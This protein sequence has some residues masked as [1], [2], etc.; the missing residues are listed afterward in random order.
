MTDSKTVEKVKQ[1]L[2]KIADM[3]QSPTSMIRGGNDENESEDIE[4]LKDVINDDIEDEEYRRRQPKREEVPEQRIRQY[5]NYKRDFSP[6]ALPYGYEAQVS[7]G[8]QRKVNDVLYHIASLDNDGK[9]IYRGGENLYDMDDLDDISGD[10]SYIKELP[11]DYT[12]SSNLEEAK[13]IL[14]RIFRSYGIGSG[15]QYNKKCACYC[16]GGLYKDEKQDEIDKLHKSGMLGSP[17]EPKQ[18]EKQEQ[19]KQ[20]EP[21]PEQPKQPKQ[22]KESKKGAGLNLSEKV[23]KLRKG[24]E[25]Y[26]MKYNALKQRG[27]TPKEARELIKKYQKKTDDKVSRIKRARKHEKRREVKQKIRQKALSK[28]PTDAGKFQYLLDQIAREVS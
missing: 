23:A 22:K 26:L 25:E 20:P 9:N 15:F 5:R 12:N 17:P 4:K 24:H 10:K 7:K 16:H 18:P 19:P 1:L 14:D 11:F 6:E 2:Y 21:E 13:Y 8:L 28:I 27:Y 3:D